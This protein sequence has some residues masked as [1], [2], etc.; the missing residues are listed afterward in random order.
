MFVYYCRLEE[1]VGQVVVKREAGRLEKYGEFTGAAVI[2]YH[3][4]GM[5]D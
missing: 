2:Q 5:E 4:E 1:M 3:I